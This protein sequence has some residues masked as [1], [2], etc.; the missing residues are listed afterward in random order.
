[1]LERFRFGPG[2]FKVDYALS[3][4]VPWEAADCQRA[5]TVHVGG[6]F[7]EIAAAEDE[8]LEGRHAAN[9]RFCW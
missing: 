4:P 3:E 8:V 1:M 7:E 2:A 5:I 9:G 6:T